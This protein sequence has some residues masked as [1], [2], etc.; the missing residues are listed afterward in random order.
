MS[1]PANPPQPTPG[2][3]VAQCYRHPGREANIRC[4]RCSR[5]ICPDCMRDAAVGF[6]CPEC[7]KEG[8]KTTRSGRTAYGGLR[9]ANPALT[10]Q[11]LIALN[12][13]VWLGVL[14][15]GWS[16]SRLVARLAL[17][18]RGVCESLGLP[19]SYYDV[20][21]EAVCTSIGGDAGGNH[22][23]SFAHIDLCAARQIAT[24]AGRANAVTGFASQR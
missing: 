5:P 13:A 11:V 1:S 17:V 6:Q 9:S 16:D 23:D 7:V 15:T 24:I 2:S 12:V 21:S 10:S 18:P 8:A 14:V 19:G 20:G 4:Q 22:A 3:G